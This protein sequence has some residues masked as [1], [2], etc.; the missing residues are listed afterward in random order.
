[1]LLPSLS[2]E[3]PLEKG[4]FWGAVSGKESASQCRRH[5]TL[6]QFL[7]WENLLAE[8]TTTHSRVLSWR[9]L[10]TEVIGRLW[11]IVLQSWT[12]LKQLSTAQHTWRSK[13]LPTAVF[14]PRN[15]INRGVWLAKVHGVTESDMTEHAC[16]CILN[17]ILVF[18]IKY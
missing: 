6:V 1:M 12:G 4:D 11:S 8:G 2:W 13:W 14:L 15:P 3:D 16:M 7:S 9:I 10:W 18:K 17:I 5:K